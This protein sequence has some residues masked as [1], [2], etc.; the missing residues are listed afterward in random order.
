MCNVLDIRLKLIAALQSFI[1]CSRLFT[2]L[3]GPDSL[4]GVKFYYDD[5]SHVE[6]IIMLRYDDICIEDPVR[7]VT[8]SIEL[9]V[10]AWNN[11]FLRLMDN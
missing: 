7:V 3:A 9:T 6:L 4:R 5:F 10:T 2:R 8:S 11:M 1:R